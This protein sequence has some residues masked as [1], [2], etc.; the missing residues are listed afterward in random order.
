MYYSAGISMQRICLF[1]YIFEE[2]TFNISCNQGKELK[3]SFSCYR[4]IVLLY[5]C[6][7]NRCLL[8]ADICMD[9]YLFFCR[10]CAFWGLWI[11]IWLLAPYVL[12]PLGVIFVIS[13]IMGGRLRAT[14][15]GLTLSLV[16]LLLIPRHNYHTRVGYCIYI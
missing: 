1:H 3:A 13:E 2:R 12:M 16:L 11:Y 10:G 14:P 15:I 8:M 5:I 4:D 6:W 9:F 7:Q